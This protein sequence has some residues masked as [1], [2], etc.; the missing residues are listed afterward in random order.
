[1]SD[2]HSKTLSVNAEANRRSSRSDGSA[3]S[4]IGDAAEVAQRVSDRVDASPLFSPASHSLEEYLVIENKHLREAGCKL[5]EAAMRVVRTHDGVHRLSLAVSG[6]A[7]AV[8]NEGGR[9]KPNTQ[10]TDAGPVT[11]ESQ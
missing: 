6:W 2:Q 7:T 8:A 10:V 4:L 1:M 3:P 9:G 5:A 11:P